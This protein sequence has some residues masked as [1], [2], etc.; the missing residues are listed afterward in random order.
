MANGTS[1]ALIR[2]AMGNAQSLL[3]TIYLRTR[4]RYMASF[5]G[6]FVCREFAINNYEKLCS[7]K[8]KFRYKHVLN[9]CLLSFL[10][11]Q[12]KIKKKSDHSEITIG[13]YQSCVIAY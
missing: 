7:F 3:K 12:N 1:G 13:S 5:C 2:L 10:H 4:I 6:E 11:Q 9:F 8:F